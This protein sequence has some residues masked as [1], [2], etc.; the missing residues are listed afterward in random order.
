MKEKETLIE[1]MKDT[2]SQALYKIEK[3]AV[4]DKDRCIHI[5][6]HSVVIMQ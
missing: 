4:L 1:Q 3:K 6:V 2:H 5:I